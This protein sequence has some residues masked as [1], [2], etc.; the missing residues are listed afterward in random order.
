MIVGFLVGYFLGT[1][2]ASRFWVLV[3]FLISFGVSYYLHL[4]E[5]LVIF[6]KEDFIK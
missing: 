6:K 2:W 1:F 3:F 4:K 5:I